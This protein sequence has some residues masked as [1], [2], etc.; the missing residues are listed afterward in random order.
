MCVTHRWMTRLSSGAAERFGYSTR[1]ALAEGPVSRSPAFTRLPLQPHRAGDLPMISVPVCC[2]CKRQFQPR[3][4]G[5][6]PQRFCRPTCR[7]AFHAVA[8][9]WALDEL[10]AGRL[11]V[12]D[13]KDGLSTTRALV[14]TAFSIS[15][16]HEVPRPEAR[17]DE[18]ALLMDE[19][20]AL[21]GDILDTLSPEELGRL[22]EPV[23]AL[24]TFIAGPDWHACYRTT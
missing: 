22:P 11:P 20:A 14:P 17:P 8:R 1:A 5:G 4:S 13:L 7:R 16:A 15:P 19:L 10:A 23:W 24:L 6:R 2:W 21:L 12:A 3:Q 18:A 9:A